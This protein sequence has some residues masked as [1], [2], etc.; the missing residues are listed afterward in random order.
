ML[1]EES[2]TEGNVRVVTVTLQIALHPLPPLICIASHRTVS[3]TED[4]FECCTYDRVSCRTYKNVRFAIE[5]RHKTKNKPFHVLAIGALHA[6]GL[7]INASSRTVL[8]VATQ[9]DF[10]S[11]LNKPQT[12]C[13]GTVRT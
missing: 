13:G 11:V 1:V 12:E 5:P 9:E 3:C 7:R 2:I 4:V 6:E 8:Q 10:K